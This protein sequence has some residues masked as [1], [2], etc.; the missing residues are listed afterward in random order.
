MKQIRYKELIKECNDSRIYLVIDDKKYILKE[1]L[2]Q[3]RLQKME[4]EILICKN[5]KSCYPNF[6]CVVPKKTDYENTFV[7]D[8]IEGRPYLE[9]NFDFKQKVEITRQ[10]IYWL[11]LFE[12]MPVDDKDYV[13]NKQWKEQLLDEISNRINHISQLSIVGSSI[14]KSVKMWL[15][16]QIN[17]IQYD[18][19]F[20]YVHNDLNKENMIFNIV[21]NKIKVSFIDFEKTIIADPLKEISKLVWLFR[22]DRE[23]GDIFWNEYIQINGYKSKTL[24]KAYWLYDIL[25]H[26]KKYSELIL[27]P[28]WKKYLDEEIA[29]LSEATEDNYRLW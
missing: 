3:D 24:L 4:K 16:Y 12:A 2:T 6:P 17:N 15:E 25:Y 19:K 20:V 8:Y 5:I 27:I 26:L 18:I 1:L 23:F 11:N 29:I 14:L 28:G 22:A 13:T 9:W 21:E 7:M 10:I